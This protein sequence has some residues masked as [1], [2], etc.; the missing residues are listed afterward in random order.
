MFERLSAAVVWWIP[1]VVWQALN[2]VYLFVLI[3]MQV[4]TA[5]LVSFAA[6]QQDGEQSHTTANTEVTETTSLDDA[7]VDTVT[8]SR[9]MI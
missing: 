5:A 8:Q 7:V 6:G 9:Q 4:G 1:A 3:I 2:P